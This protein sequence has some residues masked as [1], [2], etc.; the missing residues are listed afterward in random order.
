MRALL[1]VH[2]DNVICDIQTWPIGSCAPSE[3]L[4]KHP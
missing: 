1:K 3:T 2:A 4:Q